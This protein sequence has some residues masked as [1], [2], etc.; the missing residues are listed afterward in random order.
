M[1]WS[2]L[3]SGTIGA[4]IGAGGA[5]AS[6]M[7]TINRTRVYEAAQA[8]RAARDALA[9]AR[10][11]NA[12]RISG[13]LANLLVMSYEDLSMLIGDEQHRDGQNLDTGRLGTTAAALRRAITVDAPLLQPDLESKM[14]AARV[15]IRRVIGRQPKHAS[16]SD[17]TSLL[18]VVGDAGDHLRDARRAAYLVY[19]EG[20]RT[21]AR[22]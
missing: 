22:P 21:A 13:E 4:V 14:K 5:L 11:S 2:N 3:L 19:G 6:T 17:L 8:D 7:L 16:R 12:L 9:Q 15:E 20:A 18:T 10:Q 1:E